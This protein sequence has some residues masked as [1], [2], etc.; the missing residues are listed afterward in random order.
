MFAA[1]AA[2]DENPS[3]AIV[4]GKSPVATGTRIV[5]GQNAS[6]GRWPWQASLRQF[7]RHICGASLINK[8]WV[9]CAAHCVGF[10]KIILTVV[11]GQQ[12]QQGSN[13]NE[14]SRSVKLIIKHPSY[15]PNTND[16]DI[17][18]LKLSSSVTFTDFIRPVCLAADNSVFHS[19]TESW[20]T[21]WGVTAEGES[22]SPNIL[23]EVEVPVIGNRQCNC[24]Y[25]VGTITDNMIC[26]GLLEGGKDSCQGDSG[27]PMVNRQNTVWIQSGIVSFGKGCARPNLPGVY[28]RVS[29]YQEWISSH[30]C[31]DPPG[32]VQF[33]STGADSDN[34]YSCSGLPPLPTSTASTS[35]TTSARSSSKQNSISYFLL[36]IAILFSFHM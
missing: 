18:L 27:G 2:A 6:A 16:N 28:T 5:G 19:G 21:G 20:I 15:D 11:L 23:Q 4:C 35:R 32:F 25:E 8:D 22:L 3:S 14:V 34:T 29:R 1:T 31:S 36:L 33:I 17:A 10:P 12:T 24:L 13:P 9:L 26:A 30:V 7:G